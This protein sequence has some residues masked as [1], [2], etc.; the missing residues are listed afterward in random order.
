MIFSLKLIEKWI[1]TVMCVTFILLIFIYMT[2]LLISKYKRRSTLLI[3][4]PICRMHGRFMFT[5]MKIKSINE[6]YFLC[7]EHEIKSFSSQ[8]F[9]INHGKWTKFVLICKDSCTQYTLQN[10][11]FFLQIDAKNLIFV[12]IILVKRDLK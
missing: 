8:T 3:L 7:S 9:H 1:Y 4:E 12:I 5:N 10:I 11:K 6:I 2:P